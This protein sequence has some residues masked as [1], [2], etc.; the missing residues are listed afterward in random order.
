MRVT[1]DQLKHMV[2]RILTDRQF[3]VYLDG[4]RKQSNAGQE[5]DGI[6]RFV[7]QHT[8]LSL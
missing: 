3:G 5:I 6:V 4:L 8:G 2:E 1:P 7:Q